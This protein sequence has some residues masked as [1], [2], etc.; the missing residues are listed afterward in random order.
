MTSCLAYTLE[1]SLERNSRCCFQGTFNFTSL[2]KIFDPKQIFTGP[3]DFGLR[4]FGNSLLRKGMSE[5]WLLR[6]NWSMKMM[7]AKCDPSDFCFFV[8]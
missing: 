3:T 4:C 6:K 2:V 7:S 8:Y 5:Q 1:M